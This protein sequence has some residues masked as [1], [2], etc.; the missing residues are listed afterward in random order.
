MLRVR[1]PVFVDVGSA[2]S[3]FRLFTMPNMRRKTFICYYL[4]FRFNSTCETSRIDLSSIPE[5]MM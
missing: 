3:F 5:K 2:T 1:P 4:W